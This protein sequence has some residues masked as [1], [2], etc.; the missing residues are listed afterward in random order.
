MWRP[1]SSVPPAGTRVQLK[2]AINDNDSRENVT[3]LG[4]L[5]PD[6]LRE[7]ARAVELSGLRLAGVDIICADPARS[8]RAGGGAASFPRNVTAANPESR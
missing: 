3:A 2:T 1:A 8:L 5:C 6:I 4:V 7:T